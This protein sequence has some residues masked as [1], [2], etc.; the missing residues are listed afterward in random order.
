MPLVGVAIVGDRQVVTWHVPN[1]LAA[2]W[3][4]LCDPDVGN[5]WLGEFSDGRLKEADSIQLFDGESLTVEAIKVNADSKDIGAAYVALTGRDYRCE[6]S[7]GH[8]ETSGSCMQIV[9]L[10]VSGCMSPTSAWI[11]HMLFF[12]ACLDGHPVRTEYF[13]IWKETI[14]A[15][16]EGDGSRALA[17]RLNM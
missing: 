14:Q 2:V 1:V 4:K 17:A 6:I 7:M 12:E 3:G 9:I 8:D 5:L 11:C 16:L 10:N 15:L 13:P